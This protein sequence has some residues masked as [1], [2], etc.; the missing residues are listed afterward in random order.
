MGQ[1]TALVPVLRMKKNNM[2]YRISEY[3]R[4][5]TV[6]R[7][8]DLQALYILAGITGNLKI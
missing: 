2:K 4:G 3:V 8:L 6:S 7:E 1:E 5:K